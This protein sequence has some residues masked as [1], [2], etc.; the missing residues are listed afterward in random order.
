MEGQI[1]YIFRYDIAA[2]ILTGVFLVRYFYSRKIST[3]LTNTFAILTGLV[4]NSSIF[5]YLSI[6]HLNYATKVPLWANTI[7][8]LLYDYFY[9]T[10]PVCFFLCMVI[11]CDSK[12]G[13]FATIL[14]NLPHLV[15]LIIIFVTPFT[16][17][18]YYF[19]ENYIY[20]RGPLF[21]WLYVQSAF[22]MANGVLNYILNWK[23]FT[24]S[25]NFTLLFFTIVCGFSVVMQLLFPRYM[26]MN[27]AIAISIIVAYLSF[28]NPIN[29]FDKEIKDLLDINIYNRD[30]FLTLTSKALE[31]HKKFTFLGIKIETFKYLSD[32]IGFDKSYEILGEVI[33]FL[34]KTCGKKSVFQLSKSKYAV[35]LSKNPQ[36]QN[37]QISQ[38]K[39]RF[40]SAF[41]CQPSMLMISPLFNQIS[42][43]DTMKSAESILEFLETSYNS[44]QYS[45]DGT[46]LNADAEHISQLNERNRILSILIDSIKNDKIEI[47]YQPI[48]NV[49]E[50]KFTACEALVRLRD[51][52]YQYIPPE[53]FIPIA[54]KNGIMQQ[55]TFQIA[56]KISKFINYS[57]IIEKGINY[58]GINVS[59]SQCIQDDLDKKFYEIMDY[60]KINPANISIEVHEAT[61]LEA[62]EIFTAS[63]E[64]MMSKNIKFTL[65]AYGTG[66]SY[67]TNLINYNFDYIKLDRSLIQNAMTDDKAKIILQQTIKM[68]RDMKYQVAICGIETE[69]MAKTV[70]QMDVDFIQGFYYSMPLPED[71]FISFISSQ[72]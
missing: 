64:K 12:P 37:E 39:N 60:Y 69:E 3:K 27:F 26:M 61:L 41:K 38:I 4:M 13:K 21:W 33:S 2:A 56:T 23:K 32:T 72:Q 30:A 31:R 50:K 7:F 63:M 11:L 47:H 14:L 29:Y 44:L 18:L 43:S 24:K 59:P 22:Y 16:K 49:A 54:E 35:L 36:V 1:R 57:H 65:D 71:Q 28:E 48:Y 17:W 58:I 8:I 52:N 67:M 51:E 45:E 68:L 46:I 42:S 62:K 6:Y 10:I 5:D 34:Q 9:Q 53:A 20:H 25:Q 70:I 40:K 55:L 15:T 66:L 19:D